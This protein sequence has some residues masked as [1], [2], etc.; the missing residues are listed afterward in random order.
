MASLQIGNNLGIAARG[1]SQVPLANVTADGA[2]LATVDNTRPF[3]PGMTV[4]FFTRATGAS[5]GV[6]DISLVDAASGNIWYTGADIAL[7]VGD[8]VYRPGHFTRVNPNNNGGASTLAGFALISAITLEDI[9]S[10]LKV[11]N[12]AYYT[13]ARMDGLTYNDLVYALRLADAPGSI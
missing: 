8:S 11:I 10:R 7:A 13:D 1:N 9:R 5:K 2:N 3:F 12:S 4:E 6:R